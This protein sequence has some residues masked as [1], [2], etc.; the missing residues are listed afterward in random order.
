MKIFVKENF[1]SVIILIAFSG[2]VLE[3][4]SEVGST[5]PYWT[6]HYG[7]FDLLLNMIGIFC[8]SSVLFH[9][10]FLI[11]RFF[12]QKVKIS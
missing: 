10:L 12:A 8:I 11:G 5:S 6:L 3:A 1:I 7:A 2:K 4:V 9:L